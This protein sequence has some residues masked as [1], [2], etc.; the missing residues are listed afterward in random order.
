MIHGIIKFSTRQGTIAILDTNT[1][2]Q[3]CYQII[4]APEPMRAPKKSK[5]GSYANRR[6]LNRRNQGTTG[7]APEALLHHLRLEAN[8]SDR[9]H[10][11]YLVK[12]KKRGQAAD[13]DR[14]IKAKVVDLVS[15]GIIREVMFPTWIANSVMVNKANGAWRMCIDYSDLD[16]ACPK[17]CYLLLEIDQ[18]VQSLEGFRFKCFLNAYKGYHQV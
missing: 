14:A 4:A 5:E 17:D 13:H 7:G 10:G 18:K 15:A 1:R 9:P 8:G 16:N 11:S 12:Q 3:H 2:A 6:P